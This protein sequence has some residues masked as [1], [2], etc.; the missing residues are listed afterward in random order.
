MFNE[1]EDLMHDEFTDVHEFVIDDEDDVL[2]APPPMNLVPNRRI[3]TSQD[4]ADELR[5]VL[6]DGYDEDAEELPPVSRRNGRII[7][8]MHERRVYDKVLIVLLLFFGN[9]PTASKPKH[10]SYS[11]PIPQVVLS[12]PR[13]PM[14]RIV[15][16]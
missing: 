15:L 13:P 1:D 16:S 11:A 6:G 5:D 10:Q 3:S 7:V 2:P 9:Q 14:Q 8:F 4:I 12:R